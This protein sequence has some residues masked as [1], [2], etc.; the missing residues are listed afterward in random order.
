[1]SDDFPFPLP[2]PSD[3]ADAVSRLAGRFPNRVSP[4]LHWFASLPSTND[5]ADRLADR[6]APDGTAVIAEQQ[7]AGRGRLGRAWFSPAGAGL[8]VSVVVRFD[9]RG[10]E[11]LRHGM[12]AAALVTL[13]AGIAFADAVRTCTHLPVEIKWPND[14]V[15]ERRKL[16]GVLTEAS[17]SRD[18]GYAV[19]GVGINLRTASYPPGIADR[20]T[21]I[22]A[23]LGRSV[24]RAALLA[25]CLAAFA[26]RV[27]DLRSG[28]A[29]A[30]LDRWR[31]L[32][33]SSNGS[34][35]EWTT[36][37]GA[38]SGMTRGI[39]D[40]GALLVD[41][42]SGVERIIAGEVRWL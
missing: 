39:D 7:T 4:G 29:A 34:C 28:N 32:A 40:D 42:G 17:G 41:T 21:S 19:V 3:I 12:N 24:D 27:S 18:P 26:E 25:E 2:V 5:Y 35:V 11:G 14:L 10:P 6:G 36:P 38:S 22:E 15:V 9:E 8:Y 30:I 31:S 1:M 16:A 33:P 20:A 23:E 13:G 37:A